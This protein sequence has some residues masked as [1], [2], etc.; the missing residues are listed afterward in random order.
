MIWPKLIAA[1][2]CEVPGGTVP[3]PEISLDVIGSGLSLALKTVPQRRWGKACVM[4]NTV[5]GI[6][7]GFALCAGDREEI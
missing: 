6:S 5:C 7:Q 2:L 4:V 1:P 3:L